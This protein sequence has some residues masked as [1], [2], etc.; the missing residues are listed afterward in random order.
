MTKLKSRFSLRRNL[1]NLVA[2]LVESKRH[3]S[4]I[5]TLHFPR[6]H[7]GFLTH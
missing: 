3:T 7:W 1:R 2:G 6:F 4:E 5:Q